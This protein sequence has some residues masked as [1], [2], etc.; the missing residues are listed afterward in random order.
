[1]D[2]LVIFYS[3][4]RFLGTPLCGGEQANFLW[5]LEIS[6]SPRK[7]CLSFLPLFV[8]S[9]FGL[10]WVGGFLVFDCLETLRE[11]AA[12]ASRPLA[13]LNLSFSLS[14]NSL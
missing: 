14:V 4:L 13:V 12:V 3:C 5:V 8:L 10:D 11:L 7:I 9:L 2:F 1:M 6:C